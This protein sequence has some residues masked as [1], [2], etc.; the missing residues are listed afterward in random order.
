VSS[1]KPQQW[2]GLHPSWCVAP[3]K[4]KKKKDVSLSTLVLKSV[5]NVSGIVTFLWMVQYNCYRQFVEKRRCTCGEV[6]KAMPQYPEMYHAEGSQENYSALSAVFTMYA[7]TM[8][9]N[10]HNHAQG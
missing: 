4:K 2:G 6:I 9:N 1:R 7:V 5:T 8:M 10:E 3:Q